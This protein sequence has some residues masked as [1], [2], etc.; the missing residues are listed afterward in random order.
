[1]IISRGAGTKNHHYKSE[2]NTFYTGNAQFYGGCESEEISPE[3]VRI[4]ATFVLSSV[5]FR[6][7]T[8]LAYKKPKTQQ[9]GHKC[10]KQNK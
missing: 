8:L 3:R 10:K 2:G 7:M 5:R 1:M 9:N 6:S 4:G